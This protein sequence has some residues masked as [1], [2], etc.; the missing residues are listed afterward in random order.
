MGGKGKTSGRT[1]PKKGRD[2]NPER[3]RRLRALDATIKRAIGGDPA[4]ADRL[5]AHLAGTLPTIRQDRT[6]TI[7]LPAALVERA[8]ALIPD[9]EADPA[10]TAARGGSRGVGLSAVVRLALLEGLAILERRHKGTS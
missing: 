7:R 5:R 1:P 9:L 6:L 8:G 4:L 10:V 3:E 2:T